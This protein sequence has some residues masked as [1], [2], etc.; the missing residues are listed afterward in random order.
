VHAPRWGGAN[1]LGAQKSKDSVAK[2]L[3]KQKLRL[4]SGRIRLVDVNKERAW[5]VAI[6]HV[7]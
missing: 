2:T 7:E 4:Q 1:I 5:Q 6:D 3:K